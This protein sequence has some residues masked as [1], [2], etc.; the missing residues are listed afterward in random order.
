M[1]SW[2]VDTKNAFNSKECLIEE[3]VL[4]GNRVSCADLQVICGDGCLN[5]NIMKPEGNSVLLCNHQFYNGQVI[6]RLDTRKSF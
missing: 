6:D 5:D 3:K 2:R 1:D 4:T